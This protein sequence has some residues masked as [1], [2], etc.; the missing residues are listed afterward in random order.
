MYVYLILTTVDAK[1]GEGVPTK[2]VATYA[3]ATLAS[4]ASTAKSATPACLTRATMAVSVS[5]R[6]LRVASGV[7][8]RLA[9]WAGSARKE[10]LA[11][12]MDLVVSTA[13]VCRLRQETLGVNATQD[14]VE[15]IAKSQVIS[16]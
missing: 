9:S 8:V 1:T 6:A 7:S 10:I 2:Q 5:H 11:L 15:L 3:C 12:T 14:T 4:Q 16:Y 13:G